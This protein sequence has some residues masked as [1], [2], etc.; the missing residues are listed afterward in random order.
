MIDLDD[1]S[2]KRK[3]ADKKFIMVVM[4]LRFT[5]RDE[6]VFSCGIITAP[7]FLR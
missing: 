4:D 2:G 7:I 5:R 6:F 1:T 3:I